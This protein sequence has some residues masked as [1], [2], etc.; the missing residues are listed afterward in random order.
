MVKYVVLNTLQPGVDPDEAYQ[1]WR[2]EHAAWAKKRF[3]PDAKKFVINR[4]VHR[5]GENNTFGFGEVYFNDV[6]TGLSAMQRIIPFRD[7]DDFRKK[8]ITV[9]QRFFVEE[10]EI[11][12]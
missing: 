3:A 1:Y 5:I 12:L 8:F 10:E 4:V 2:K 7:E 6:E 11:E 9:Q